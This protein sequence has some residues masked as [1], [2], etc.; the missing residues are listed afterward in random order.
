MLKKYLSYWK[1][2]SKMTLFIHILKCKFFCLNKK[3]ENICCGF[4]KILIFSFSNSIN[5]WF[6][7]SFITL[8]RNETCSW[9]S[10]RFFQ[11]SHYYILIIV[12]GEEWFKKWRFCLL[13]SSLVVVVVVLSKTYPTAH[14]FNF[15]PRIIFC[16]VY[17]NSSKLLPL[18]QKEVVLSNWIR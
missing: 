8:S 15:P 14:V 3:K 18:F 17:N 2:M 9:N 13:L 16:Y 12:F 11:N 10:F 5:S 7:F 4:L 6:L 1:K